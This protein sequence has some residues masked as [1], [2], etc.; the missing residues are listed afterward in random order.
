MPTTGNLKDETDF[1]LGFQRVQSV[2]VWEPLTLWWVGKQ[3][4]KDTLRTY[5]GTYFLQEGV[6]S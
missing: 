2:M 1:H 4:G 3:P 5:L 6:T